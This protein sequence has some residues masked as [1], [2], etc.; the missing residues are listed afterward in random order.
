MLKIYPFFNKVYASKF[1]KFLFESRNV[2][3]NTIKN[4]IEITIGTARE[5][6]Q[7]ILNKFDIKKY[8]NVAEKINEVKIMGINSIKVSKTINLI[9]SDFWRPRILKTRF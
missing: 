7:L 4:R 3:T 1:I 8:D 6:Y 2:K 9:V 5:K